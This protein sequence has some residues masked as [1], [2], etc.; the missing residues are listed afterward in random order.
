MYD[1]TNIV[2]DE[3]SQIVNPCWFLTQNYEP[4][5]K[6]WLLSHDAD[7]FR[8]TQLKIWILGTKAARLEE[9]GGPK[10][11]KGRKHGLLPGVRRR[12]RPDQHGEVRTH[13]ELTRI[14]W[15]RPSCIRS[16]NIGTY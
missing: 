12:T 6:I 13:H 5:A 4:S 11:L 9:I 3:G 8:F 7:G 1:F 14:T 15:F 2:G 16:H 10:S